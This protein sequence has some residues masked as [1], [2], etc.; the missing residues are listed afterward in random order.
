MQEEIKNGSEFA[1]L[2]REK[3]IDVSSASLGGAI[4]FVSEEQTNIDDAIT[5]M[6]K[7]AKINEVS[8]P[9]VL[10]DGNYGLILVEE[11]IEGQS[12]TYDEAKDH[13]KR[14]IAMQELPASINPEAFWADF[15]ATWFYGI[16]TK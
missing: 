15:N 3:S 9:F 11:V 7:K 10:T 6:V 5:T 4:G 13:I 8:N 1:V 2:A 16:I 12:F 14:L